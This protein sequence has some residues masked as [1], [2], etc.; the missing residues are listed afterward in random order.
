MWLVKLRHKKLQMLLTGAMLLAVSA[1]LNMSL[2]LMGELASFSERAINEQNCPDGYIFTI[3]TKQF[4]DNFTDDH[5]QDDIQKVSPLHGKAV[6]VPIRYGEKDITQLYDMVLAADDMHDFNYFELLTGDKNGPDTGEVWLSEVL[7][8]PNHIKPGDKIV[9]QYARPLE[10]TVTGVYRSTCFPKGIGY[11][12]MLVN[13]TDL[14]LIEGEKD[15]ALFAVNIKNYSDDHLK[16]LFQDSSYS[17]ATR[18]RNDVQASLMEYSASLGAIGAMAAFT[19]FIVAMIILWYIIKNNLLKEFRTIGVYKSLGYTSKDIARFYTTGYLVIGGIAI[20]TGAIAALKLVKIIGSMLTEYVDDFMLTKT[21]SAISI[22]TIFIL[23]ILLS[24]NLKLAFRKVRSI[25]PVEAITIGTTKTEQ[26]LPQS[27]I[28]NARSPLAIAVNELFKYKKASVM[29]VL[30]IT[31]SMFLCMFFQ[32]IWFSADTI[33]DNR[34]RWFCL[35]ESDAYISGTI[36]ADLQSYL[37]ENEYVKTVV[38]GDFMIGYCKPEGYPNAPGFVGYDAYSDFSEE[39]TGI[40]M[41][42]GTGPGNNQEVAVG[43]NLLSMLSLDLGDFVSLTLNGITKQYKISGI[44][45]TVSDRGRKIM[46]TTQAVAECKDYSVSRAYVRLNNEGDYESFKQDIESRFASSTV[47]REWFAME[48]S[49]ESIQSMLKS[50]SML[51]VLAFFSFSLLCIM[52]VL[53]M[54]MKNWRKKY[55]IMKSLGFTANYLIG[56][57]TCKYFMIAMV[58]SVVSLGLHH[59]FSQKIASFLL[60]DAFSSSGRLVAMIISGFM[61]LIVMTA[62]VISLSV[63]QISP[64]E[65]ME[66]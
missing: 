20:T 33:L 25:T 4:Q 26:K 50:I 17:V 24:V 44:Y 23:M 62:Y 19:I 45:E 37:Q 47:S 56:Q 6:T 32:M 48:N 21:A 30:A 66:E 38:C 54:D 58:S 39:V 46:L 51:L 52:I 55:G 10:L 35:P 43:K 64:L 3:G 57:N 41:L 29:T 9:L 2:C 18:S 5:Y 49:V 27:I 63:K 1:L 31:M 53:T 40:K 36:S 16:E 11:S 7:T 12:P 65:L 61:V 60:L 8:K 14:A 34:S 59:L 28:K 42:K 13:S 15:A 22:I